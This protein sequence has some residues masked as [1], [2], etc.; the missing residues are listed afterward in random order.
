M[1]GTKHPKSLTGENMNMKS[2]FISLIYFLE[3]DYEKKYI[4]KV[5]ILFN[6]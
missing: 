3:H 6:Q 1:D 2:V 4:L 5:D